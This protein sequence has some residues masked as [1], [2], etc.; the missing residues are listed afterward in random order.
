VQQAFIVG[1]RISLRASIV[2]PG[3][4]HDCHVRERRMLQRFSSDDA[5]R[6]ILQLHRQVHIQRRQR[7]RVHVRGVA[8]QQICQVLERL[9]SLAIL[10][11]HAPMQHHSSLRD[12]KCRSS[13]LPVSG[14]WQL[15]AASRR[16]ACWPS[17]MTLGWPVAFPS[18]PS[19]RK[20]E[21]KR[22]QTTQPCNTRVAS[23]VAPSTS[24]V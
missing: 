14:R 23:C 10:L 8:D 20:Q 16:A 6:G 3:Y 17:S 18:E 4:G 24:A 19:E 2:P 5:L 12:G 15:K 11:R 7:M 1:S 9:R 22:D 13:G 21:Y